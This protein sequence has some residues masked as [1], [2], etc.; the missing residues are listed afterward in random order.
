MHGPTDRANA[1][2]ERQPDDELFQGAILPAES[3][4]CAVTFILGVPSISSLRS[5]VKVR[6]LRDIACSKR[7][8]MCAS[9]SGLQINSNP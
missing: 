1:G 8:R 3:L 9:P 5:A 2:F 4:N 6:G 7:A